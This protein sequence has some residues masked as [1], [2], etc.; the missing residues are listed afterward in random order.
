MRAV[1]G[2]VSDGEH[3]IAAVI[4]GWNRP[5]PRGRGGLRHPADD[6][7]LWAMGWILSHRSAPQ[8]LLAAQPGIPVSSRHSLLSVRWRPRAPEL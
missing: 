7:A 4:P 3:D 1:G 2:S 6:G 8:H 5:E